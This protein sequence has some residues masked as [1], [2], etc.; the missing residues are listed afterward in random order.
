MGKKIL[1]A[2]ANHWTSPYQVGSHHYARIFAK[3][4]WEVLFI[5]DPISP[6]HYLMKEKNQLN[7]RA[8]I[9]KG[10][11]ESGNKNIS[12]YVPL[13]L[14]TP[15]EKPFFRTGF[16]TNNW[17]RFT[18]PNIIKYVKSCGFGNVD[19]L[20]FDSI[21]QYFWIKS[22]QYGKSIFRISDRMDAFKKISP[23]LKKLE[24]S[25]K[26]KA[27]IIIYTAKDL[28]S[29][30]EDY[31]DKT[32]FVPNGVDLEH[33]SNSKKEIPNDLKTIPKPLAIYI[34]AVDEWFDIDLMASIAKK[35]N[36]ISFV[37]I[38]DP[39]INVS[40]LKNIQNIYLLG[41]RRYEDIPAYLYNSDVG[42]IPF[43]INHP[44]VRS[45]NPIKLYEYMACG[46]PVVA[47]K[48][49][50][51]ELIESL[52]FLASDVEEFGEKLRKALNLK[53]KETLVN[54]AIQNSW[55][56]RFTRIKMLLK[57]S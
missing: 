42:I 48:W 46:L 53:N 32:A 34:G 21:T 10:L 1:I 55:N 28:E 27:D 38:G 24:I 43:N 57:E 20:W 9:R 4:G 22:I 7:E 35:C 31:K 41:K 33:F 11:V 54:F 3:N 13:A 36:D 30:L 25:L 39:K 19:L 8:R 23:N 37:I 12:I 26:E 17:Y 49:K 50:E 45:V 52:A 16:V 29:Y 14:F 15:N 44:V 18:V 47:T 40:T 2:A 51:L 56:E 6:F 5:S